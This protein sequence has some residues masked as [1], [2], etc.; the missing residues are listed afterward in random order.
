MKKSLICLLTAVAVLLSLLTA[1]VFAART[2]EFSGT[3]GE[4][5]TWEFDPIMGFLRIDGEGAIPDYTYSEGAPWYACRSRIFRVVIGSGIT[6]I[7]DYAFNECANLLSVDASGCILD[8]I[9]E[10]AMSGCGALESVSFFPGESLL[11]GADAFA[12]CAALTT[13]NLGA[14][15]GEIG[16]SAFYGCAALEEI[17]LPAGLL[18]LKENSFSGCAALKSLSL[19]ENL[20][21]IGKGC[22]RD[23]T[24]LT[25]LSF[26]AG[27]ATVERDAF[28]GCGPL[29]LT[30]AGGAPMFAPASD[31]TASFPAE[32]LLRV[33]YGTTGWT[34][35]ICKGYATEMVYPSLTEVFRDM[36]ENAWYIPSVQH[37]YF[38][39]Y[40]NGVSENTFAPTSPL[41][42][43]ELVT[44][45]Y[46]T[47]GMPEVTA[48]NPFEDV[49]EDAFYYDAVRWAQSK[50]VV[51]G[52]SATEF[53][54]YDY[55]NRE[56]IATILFRYAAQLEMEISQRSS[57]ENFVDA[58]EISGYARDPMSWCVAIGLINGKPGGVLDPFGI[59]TRTEIAKILT[60]FEACAAMEDFLAQDRWM[61]DYTEPGPDIDREDPNYLYAQDILAEINKMR[62]DIGLSA[63]EWD[64][65]TYLAAQLRAQELTAEDGFSH[66]RPDGSNYH[67]VFDQFGIEHSTRNEIIARGFTDAESLVTAWASTGS[68]GPVISALV[69]S[70]AAVGIYQEPPAEDGTEGKYY[71]VLLV[72]G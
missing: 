22:F 58:D 33:P 13:L 24:A 28:E 18:A 52:V 43:G 53:R 40:M 71:Y 7:G 30:F 54:P 72:I 67:T 46:R 45:L 17:T 10:G 57:F 60:A 47:A 42:R 37:V 29:T 41:S 4:S 49:S 69:Y 9:G 19:P 14:V 68:S 50:G 56:Q 31:V 65:N 2:P 64:D 8:T 27:L 35:P 3:C 11:V 16:S 62:T 63:L 51:T 61:D 39:G 25:E 48:V 26:P 12:N 70:T 38:N 36:E 20:A 21:Y 15:E 66:T 34:W 59:A 55:I 32:A 5:I 23:C 44:V 6:G 1:A